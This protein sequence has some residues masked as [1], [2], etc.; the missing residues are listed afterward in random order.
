MC[1]AEHRFS[2][3]DY[4]PNHRGL[5]PQHGSKSQLKTQAHPHRAQTYKKLLYKKLLSKNTYWGG[6]KIEEIHCV[7]KLYIICFFIWHEKERKPQ[8]WIDKTPKR[9]PWLHFKPTCSKLHK[10]TSHPIPWTMKASWK[11][12]GKLDVMSWEHFK[13][14]I[15]DTLVLVMKKPRSILEEFYHLR[16]SL[17]TESISAQGISLQIWLSQG[18]VPFHYTNF[19]SLDRGRKCNEPK[20]NIFLLLLLSYI[21]W[22]SFHPME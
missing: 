6:L 9:K 18:K 20:F 10:K 4:L 8:S 11:V 12:K 22:K 1:R 16:F 2:P 14:Y 7:L 15:H 21:S 19:D 3:G 13:N 5:K 17:C